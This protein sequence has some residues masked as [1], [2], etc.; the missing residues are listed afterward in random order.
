M[1]KFDVSSR[2]EWVATPVW[3]APGDTLVFSASGVWV[4]ATI[5]CSA[6]GYP[7][8]LFYA[9]GL[10]PRIKDDG[11]YF[12]LMGRIVADGQQPASDDPG[13]TFAIGIGLTRTFDAKGRLFVFANDREGFYW[14]NWGSVTLSVEKKSA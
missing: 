8:P 3:V 4:D 9:A 2:P 7:A 5:P 13:A 14:N 12:R 1:D 11:R 6:N 10:F